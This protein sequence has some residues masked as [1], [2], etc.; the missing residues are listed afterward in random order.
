MRRKVCGV[1]LF[2]VAT[3][4]TM[5]AQTFT[6]LFKF[7][8]PNGEMPVASLVQ[9][10]DGNL[11]GTT[12]LGGGTGNI[13]VSSGCGTVFK[14]TPG[15]SLTTLHSFIEI[16]GAFPQGQ[17]VQGSD[18]NFYGTTAV[19]GPYLDGT[20]F[21]ITPEGGLTSLFNFRGS[22]G[23]YAW[24][25]LLQAANGN[26]YGTTYYGGLHD[27]GEVFEVTPDGALTPLHSFNGPDGE[28]PAATLI[29]GPNGDMYGTTAGI[30]GIL[31]ESPGCGTIFV[32]TLD[33]SVTTLHHFVGADGAGPS[34][35]TLG[36]DGNFY[37]STCFGGTKHFGTI[38][39]MT[40]EGAITTLHRFI[41]IVSGYCPG[42]LLQATDG[43]FYGMTDNGGTGSC[44][45]GCGTIFRITPSGIFTTLYSF[46]RTDGGN[47]MGS[48]IQ[49]TDGKLY[50]TTSAFWS[51]HHCS[52][53]CGTVFG[54]DVGL[55][56]FVRTSPSSG[57]AG[58]NILVFG[59]R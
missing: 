18:G 46:R 11:Y 55:P 36:A 17:L 6:N 34:Q 31:C 10:I 21:Q 30:G 29:Q 38:F 5:R 32:V 22:D 20:I 28:Y 1:F 14:I 48:L 9:G 26:F 37:G 12:S 39:K 13:C 51:D 53:S 42:G 58:S 19:G 8:G 49:G 23:S 50:G 45:I 41:D 4:P 57:E 52:L 44:Y 27:K 7:D 47:P 33:G 24:A 25:G 40:P 3:A 59:R 56:P 54:F 15:G 35:L 43:N 16:D 2:C